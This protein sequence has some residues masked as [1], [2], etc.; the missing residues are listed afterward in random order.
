MSLYRKQ[1]IP[2]SAIDKYNK[3]K[4][5]LDGPIIRG[6]KPIYNKDEKLE[7][8]KPKTR[9][10]YERQFSENKHNKEFKRNW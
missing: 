7:R 1:Y 3:I 5:I 8:T 9:F 10:E 6:V 2:K 4:N